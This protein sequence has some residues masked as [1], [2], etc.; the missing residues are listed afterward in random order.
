VIL[1]RDRRAEERHDPVARVLVDRPLEAVHAVGQDLEEAIEDAMPLLGV[2]ALSQ[3]HRALDVGEEHR[4]LLA[5]A[6]Q[7]GLA[8]EDLVG[9]VL[10]RVVAGVALGRGGLHLLR[11][12]SPARVAEL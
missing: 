3:L 11:D 10:G 2:D 1:V 8:L 5:L 7:R 6:L 12:G 4:H 9:Q